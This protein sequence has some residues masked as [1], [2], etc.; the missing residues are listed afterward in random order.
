MKDLFLTPDL[1]RV[2]EDHIRQVFPEEGCGM[3]A[4]LQNRARVVIPVTNRLH[5][6]TRFEMDPLEQLDAMETIEREGLII[7]GFF[8]SHPTGPDHPSR[9]DL[10]EFNYPGVFYLIWSPG[11]A[12]WQVR[13]FEIL[14][15][16]FSELNLVLGV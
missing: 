7:L 14:K 4:G 2:M 1:H 16:R 11:E 8:H 15:D 3:V 5:S 9:T 6:P 12:G 10:A 13:G